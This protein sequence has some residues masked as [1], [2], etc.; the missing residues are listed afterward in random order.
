MRDTLLIILKILNA[1]IDYALTQGD[2]QSANIKRAARNRLLEQI[3]AMP[4]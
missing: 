2:I 1:G 3:N 4:Q